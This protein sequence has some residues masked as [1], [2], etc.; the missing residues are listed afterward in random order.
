MFLWKKKKKLTSQIC[1]KRLVSSSARPNWSSTFSFT[2]IFLLSISSSLAWNVDMANLEISSSSLSSVDSLPLLPMFFIFCIS[3]QASL[4]PQNPPLPILYV[5]PSK[6]LLLET[7]FLLKT[8]Q[9]KQK[10]KLSPNKALRL[11][12]CFRLTTMKARHVKQNLRATFTQSYM[13][14]LGT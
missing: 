11:L 7:Y 8:F 10:K 13:L 3:H 14:H 9:R 4:L 5:T 1:A 6:S 2:A 12:T